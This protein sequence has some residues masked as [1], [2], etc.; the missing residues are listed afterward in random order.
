MVTTENLNHLLGHSKT[1]ISH[2]RELK[3]ARGE[4][5][6]VFSVLSLERRENKTH[7]AF[8]AELLNPKGTHLKGSIFLKLFLKVIGDKDLDTSNAQVKVEHHIGTI[9][10]VAKTG[11]RIDIYICDKKGY[12]ISI[13]NKIDAGDQNAQVER[14]C[15]F[16]KGTNKVYYLTLKGTEPSSSSCGELKSGQDFQ[17]ISYKE[18]VHEW[19]TACLKESVDHPILRETIKQYKILIQKLT[20]IMDKSHQ[21]KLNDLMLTHI[22]E[23]AYISENFAKVSGA[24]KEKLRQAVITK[25]KEVLDPKY[26]VYPGHPADKYY[27]QIWIKYDGLEKSNMFFGVES[28]S[29]QGHKGGALFLGVYSLNGKKNEYTIKSERF[30]NN[31]YN[32]SEIPNYEQ[33]SMNLAN[34][35]T[36]QKLHSDSAFKEE[37]VNHIVSEVEAYLQLNDKPLHDF[38]TSVK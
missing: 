18:Q 7:S 25:L 14:Y 26:V 24:I 5:F 13:E 17:V 16:K 27:S 37:L 15:N 23:A 6:N 30:T 35:E 9:N 12:S 1:I 10:D 38:L 36:L 28:F 8:L 34:P 29:G 31:W 20:S 19:M 22:R 33:F 21:N 32:L 4:T 11:G 3:A 2:Q